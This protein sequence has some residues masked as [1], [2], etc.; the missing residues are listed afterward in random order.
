MKHLRVI[1]RHG[2]TWFTKSFTKVPTMRKLP[3]LCPPRVRDTICMHYNNNLTLYCA[4]W[5]GEDSQADSQSWYAVR[6][7]INEHI[8]VH[9]MDTLCKFNYTFHRLVEYQKAEGRAGTSLH[10][11]NGDS[12]WKKKSV[13]QNSILS[14][15]FQFGCQ[16]NY[17]PTWLVYYKSI[18]EA[19]NIPHLAASLKVSFWNYTI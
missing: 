1:R 2:I 13:I 5:C 3:W 15:Y 8:F 9:T 7:R 17:K 18:A 4:L 14:K 11:S 19:S 10:A 12:R 6:G 16:Q